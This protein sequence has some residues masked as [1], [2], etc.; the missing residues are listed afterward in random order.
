MPVLLCS[1]SDVCSYRFL[2]E[3]K[4]NI[5]VLRRHWWQMSV[6]CNICT[7]ATERSP[8][9]SCASYLPL[10]VTNPPAACTNNLLWSHSV[11]TNVGSDNSMITFIRDKRVG[12]HRPEVAWGEYN[13]PHTGEAW[14]VVNL[15]IRGIA[16]LNLIWANVM[17]LRV[18]NRKSAIVFAVFL[19]CFFYVYLFF[20]ATNV[21][22]TATEWK[23]NCSK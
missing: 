21:R 20:F 2:K 1:C 18:P 22:T 15:T 11:G 23:L 7:E 5:K 6:K 4:I 8:M 9:D 13:R 10:A 17:S 16:F 19:Y 14:I 3:V 12:W